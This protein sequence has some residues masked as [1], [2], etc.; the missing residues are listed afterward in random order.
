M[1]LPSFTFFALFSEGDFSLPAFFSVLLAEPS[2]EK[3]GWV[4]HCACGRSVGYYPGIAEGIRSVV[5]WRKRWEEHG[6]W[7]REVV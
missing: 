7:D 4:G 1:I 3:E 2:G 5:A 6:D